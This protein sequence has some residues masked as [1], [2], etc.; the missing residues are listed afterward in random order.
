VRANGRV[1]EALDAWRARRPRA[2]LYHSALVV[3][4][5][6]GRYVVENAWPIP[7]ARGASRGVVV[8]GPV[9]S[10]RLGRFRALR[11]EV[12]RWREGVIADLAWALPPVRVTSDP[13]QARRVL[14]AVPRVPA[15][16]WGRDE[17]GA[18]EMWNSNSVVSWI[19]ASAGVRV[20]R[21]APPRGGR[22][23]G[24]AAGVIEARDARVRT[25]LF[26]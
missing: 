12:R 7:D 16:V 1:Y 8:E 24:W 19:L 6:E 21:I 10:R 26:A 3:R 18:G 5:Q 4:T 14:D 22:A 11:Y 9:F 23:P 20:E 2:A 15:H 25:S 17:R 13:S